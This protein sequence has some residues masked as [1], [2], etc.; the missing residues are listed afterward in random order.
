MAL[1]L[2]HGTILTNLDLFLFDMKN[3]FTGLGEFCINSALNA[4]INDSGVYFAME[5]RTSRRV[6]FDCKVWHGTDVLHTLICASRA[7]LGT[8]P[9]CS[10]NGG[11]PEG[12]ER[13]NGDKKLIWQR[14]TYRGCSEIE[15]KASQQRVFEYFE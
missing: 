2:K 14:Q 10:L 11:H 9:P 1:R 3:K 5:I 15:P 6:T 8:P 13:L 12:Y 4:E 7:R